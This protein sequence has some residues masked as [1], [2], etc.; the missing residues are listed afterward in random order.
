MCQHQIPISQSKERKVNEF[1]GKP[2]QEVVTKS[3]YDGAQR[4]E[5]SLVHTSIYGNKSKTKNLKVMEW[6]LK[7]KADEG[8]E[9]EN[10]F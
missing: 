3:G 1:D 5:N 10:V 7:T 4:F 2:W 9:K 6:M 8:E